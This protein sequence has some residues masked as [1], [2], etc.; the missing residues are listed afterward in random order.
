MA[1]GFKFGIYYEFT[2]P[3]VTPEGDACDSEDSSIE[4]IG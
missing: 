1:A 3:A 4:S 2:Q